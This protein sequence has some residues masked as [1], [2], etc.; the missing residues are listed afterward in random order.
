[1]ATKTRSS[2]PKPVSPKPMRQAATSSK[3]MKPPQPKFPAV[4]M[5]L[6]DRLN[7]VPFAYW[8]ENGGRTIAIQWDD[9]SKDRFD[10][11]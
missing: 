4:V 11:G 3:E 5:G 8:Y 9:L 1:M 10:V 7:K 6:A 2:T